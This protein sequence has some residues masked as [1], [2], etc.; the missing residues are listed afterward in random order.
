MYTAEY[1][2]SVVERSARYVVEEFCQLG[3]PTCKQSHPL[4][5]QCN[6]SHCQFIGH[7]HLRVSHLETAAPCIAV[8]QHY[9]D[10]NA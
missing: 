3:L 7:V 5:G 6:I 1:S 4:S 10:T 9:E 8:Y 2:Y